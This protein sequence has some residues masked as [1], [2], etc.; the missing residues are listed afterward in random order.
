LLVVYQL[1]FAVTNLAVVVGAGSLVV[2]FR[3]ASGTERQ[4]LQWV[5]PRP[6]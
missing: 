6:R 5:A 2:R 4:Q 3:R 1:T